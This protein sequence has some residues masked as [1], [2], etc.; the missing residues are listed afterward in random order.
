GAVP[1]PPVRRTPGM[2]PALV[3]LG[4]AVVVIAVFGLMSALAPGTQHTPPPSSTPKKVVGTT[5]LAVPAFNALK[6][7]EQPGTPP[8]NIVNALTIPKGAVVT[9]HSASASAT[10]YDEQIDFSVPGADQA[11]VVAFYRT[12]LDN[13][14]WK[15]ISVGPATNQPTTTQVLAQAAGDDGWYWEAGALVS[16]T[17]FGS[18]NSQSTPFVIRLFQVPDAN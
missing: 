6:P 11:A 10:G 14:G 9:D 3:V 12:Q 1:L 8:Q 2:R 17:T 4:I 15:R 7:I 13:N 5:L 18:G 16:P